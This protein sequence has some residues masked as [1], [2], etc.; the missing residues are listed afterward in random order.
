MPFSF[1]QENGYHKL[2]QLG[3]DGSCKHQASPEA[4]FY[5]ST[6]EVKSD[7]PLEPFPQ[8]KVCRIRIFSI[9]H[10]MTMICSHL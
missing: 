3:S 8:A 5:V 1:I 6:G 2:G 9:L 7:Q 10:G 4:I